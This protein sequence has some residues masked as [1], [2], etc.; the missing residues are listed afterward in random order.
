MAVAALRRK[1]LVLNEQPSVRNLLFLLKRYE[2]ENSLE[3]TSDSSLGS[4]DHKEFDAVV[5]DLRPPSGG[6]GNEVRGIKNIRG[7]WV[8]KLLVIIAEVN[9]PKTLELLER[10]LFDGLPEA[11]LWLVSNPHNSR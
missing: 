5:L 7:G 4:L 8:G 2:R 3:P 9:G 10:Y 1:V 6:T 11:L